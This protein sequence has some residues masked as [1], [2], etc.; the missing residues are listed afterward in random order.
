MSEWGSWSDCSKPCGQGDTYKKRHVMTAAAY[1]GIPCSGE[2]ANKG[3][4]GQPCALDCQVSEWGTWG[5]CSE[6]CGPGVKI[7]QR[8]IKQKNNYGGKMCPQTSM[9]GSCT[10]KACAVDCT[11]EWGGWGDC[12]KECGGG[13]QYRHPEVNQEAAYGGAACPKTEEKMCNDQGCAMDC[14]VSGWGSWSQCSEQ[15]GEGYQSHNREI[16]RAA[17]YGGQ[18][19]P[20][21]TEQ[22]DCND[23]PCASDCA[24]E[25]G[26]WGE[27]VSVVISN[28]R[29]QN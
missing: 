7:R 13:I 27:C 9:E 16:E 11:V 17:A 29:R 3:C 4:N 19:C 6:A 14:Q 8:S 10:D 26:A 2:S 5:E 18:S 23:A 28:I 21:V 1:G 12:S 20:E 15:C 25:W 24:F 22:R